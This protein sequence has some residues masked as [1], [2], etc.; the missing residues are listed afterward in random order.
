MALVFVAGLLAVILPSLVKRWR[1]DLVSSPGVVI[2][3]G[4]L[5]LVAIVVFALKL[6]DY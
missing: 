1:S 6:L 3:Q 5:L 4:V 2:A